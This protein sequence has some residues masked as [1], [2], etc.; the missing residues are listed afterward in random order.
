MKKKTLKLNYSKW[1][2]GS[3]GEHKTGEGSNSFLNKEGNMC[4]LGQFSLQMDKKMT[5]K[6]ILDVS[7]PSSLA[8]VIPGLSTMKDGKIVNTPL[9]EK[10]VGI[11]DE[12]HTTPTEKIKQFREIFSKAGY[13]IKVTHRPK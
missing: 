13:N 6:C 1:R 7:M 12:E 10:A 3:D 9:A 8:G 4:V 5:A 2:S 11:N